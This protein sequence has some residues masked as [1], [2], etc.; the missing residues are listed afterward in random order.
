MIY[1]KF[2]LNMVVPSIKSKYI[3]LID[4]E[5][6]LWRKD[7]IKPIKGWKKVEILYIVSINKKKWCTFCIMDQ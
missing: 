6:V 1:V 4:R 5:I 7:E 2:C 3:K